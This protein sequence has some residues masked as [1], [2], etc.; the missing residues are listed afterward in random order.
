MIKVVEHVYRHNLKPDSH[1]W[2][3]WRHYVNA[4]LYDPYLFSFPTNLSVVNSKV[5]ERK[6]YIKIYRGLIALLIHTGASSE[7]V[8]DTIVEAY[9]RE[10]NYD[11]YAENAKWWYMIRNVN[12]R[13]SDEA[14]VS[15]LLNLLHFLICFCRC[16]DL[17]FHQKTRHSLGVYTHDIFTRQTRLSNLIENISNL[18]LKEDPSVDHETAYKDSANYLGHILTE[19]TMS[20]NILSK[21]NDKTLTYRLGLEN[22]AKG[23]LLTYKYNLKK[24]RMYFH[25]VVNSIMRNNAYG[26][27]IDGSSKKNA[28]IYLRKLVTKDP[29]SI[30]F[31]DLVLFMEICSYLGAPNYIINMINGNHEPEVSSEDFTI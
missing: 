28:S 18:S 11:D 8:A 10:I 5:K 17:Q 24:K 19:E 21:K 16:F 9:C 7:Q 2:N 6:S 30:D 14:V 13:R 27:I 23:L 26:K 20:K 12:L 29:E 25:Q 15:D 31:V 1:Y 3:G 4:N 22:M